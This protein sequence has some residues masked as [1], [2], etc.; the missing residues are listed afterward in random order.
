MKK[1]LSLWQL[2][3]FLFSAIAGVVLHFLYDWTEQSAFVAPF[4]AI[5]ESIWEHMKLLFFP[6]FLFALVERQFVGDDYENYWCAKLAGILLGLTLIPVVYY[7][8]TGIFGVQLDWLNIAIF[9]VAVAAAYL[10][11]IWLLK[12]ENRLCLSP[13]LALLI[14]CL[15]GFAFVVFTYV[16][17][18][19]PLFQEA[20]T[21]MIMQKSPH[22]I[23]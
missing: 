5:N 15:I 1:S 6:L 12:Q 16:Q 18:K 21:S 23:S 11:E 14:L 2:A 19:I 20:Q 10:L 22:E 3:G 9:F 4:S 7:S 17:P 13:L 8:Y